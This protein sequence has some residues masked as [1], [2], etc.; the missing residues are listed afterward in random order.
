[1]GKSE[2]LY[3][4]MIFKI[5]QNI[6]LQKSFFTFAF[7]VCF[8]ETFFAKSEEGICGKVWNGEIKWNRKG[9]EREA[10][11]DYKSNFESMF[12]DE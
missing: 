3:L 5:G 9:Y 2:T 11:Q 4:Q 1:M 8:Y 12:K 10:M 6:T 7:M